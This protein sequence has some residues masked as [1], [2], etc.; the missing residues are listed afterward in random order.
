MTDRW[1]LRDEDPKAGQRRHAAGGSG[2]HSKRYRHFEQE[3]MDRSRHE[4]DDGFKR[5]SQKLERRERDRGDQRRERFERATHTNQNQRQVLSDYGQYG[6]GSKEA[7]RT[8]DRRFRDQE[9]LSRK[10]RRSS[11]SYYGNGDFGYSFDRDGRFGHDYYGTSQFGPGRDADD[12]RAPLGM[13]SDRY[14]WAQSPEHDRHDTD[15][16]ARSE[17]DFGSTSCL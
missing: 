15:F 14:D 4:F 6:Q 16:K 10:G 11:D 17:R 12:F 8:A 13:A 3:Q 1:E 7:W 2:R 5:D 9:G